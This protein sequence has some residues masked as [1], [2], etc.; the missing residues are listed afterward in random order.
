MFGFGRWDTAHRPSGA[1]NFSAFSPCCI[2]LK[3]IKYGLFGRKSWEFITLPNKM[4][5]PSIGNVHN[6]ELLYLRSHWPHTKY[7]DVAQDLSRV[8]SPAQEPYRPA[9][10]PH[11]TRSENSTD[12]Q[13]K[14]I[15]D[16]Q[17]GEMYEMIIRSW[18]KDVVQ[19]TSSFTY[20]GLKNF[21]WLYSF[22]NFHYCCASF[23][24]ELWFW[25]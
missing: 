17:T 2:F 19:L 14:L 11:G 13:W 9:C 4:S 24:W 21:S 15:I 1:G 8:S 22:K 6:L 18:L 3:I 23:H 12:S 5:F 25:Q 10:T 7:F 16:V 20:A